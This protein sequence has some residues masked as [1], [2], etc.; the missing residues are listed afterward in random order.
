V[1]WVSKDTN[2]ELKVSPDAV[3]AY[4]C[5]TSFAGAATE[6]LSTWSLELFNA[7]TLPPTLVGVRTTLGPGSDNGGPE[8][9]VAISPIMTV[10]SS[11]C[12][13]LAFPEG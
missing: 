3:N 10:I 2:Q 9:A 1:K 7:G 4:S 8:N 12:N 11:V 13:R 5:T 6:R